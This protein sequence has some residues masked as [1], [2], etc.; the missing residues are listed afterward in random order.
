[1]LKYTVIIQPEAEADLDEAF[2]YLQNIQK[3]LG[4]DL[5]ANFTD[6]I[7]YLED[8]PLMFQTVFENKRRAVIERFKYNVIYKIKGETVYILAIIHG[9]KNPK[10]WQKR[11]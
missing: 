10:W 1:M 6:I 7:S 9:K 8:N 11:Y 4:F 2:E 5:L 3:D